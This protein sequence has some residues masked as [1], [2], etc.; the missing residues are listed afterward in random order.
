MR[1]FTMTLA[2]FALAFNAVAAH[3]DPVVLADVMK[4]MGVSWKVIAKNVADPNQ[5]PTVLTESEKLRGFVVQAAGLPLSDKILG[6]MFPKPEDRRTAPL[7]FQKTIAILLE[8]VN[9]LS[10]ALMAKDTATAVATVKK[11]ADLK[12][13]GHTMFTPPDSPVLLQD[14]EDEVQDK[15]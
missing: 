10:L 6:Q 13:F 11:I 12:A 8:D 1:S 3:A 14:R 4:S 9:D 7:K 15:Q 2:A 5:N